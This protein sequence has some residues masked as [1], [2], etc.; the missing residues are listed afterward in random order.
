MDIETLAKRMRERALEVE[1]HTSDADKQA[2]LEKQKRLD[3]LKTLYFNA[4]RWAGGARDR[5]AREAFEQVRLL[6]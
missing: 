5:K 1:A 6:G 4:G 3:N 2:R